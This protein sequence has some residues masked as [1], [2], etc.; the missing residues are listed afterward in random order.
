[1]VSRRQ[2]F[3]TSSELGVVITSRMQKERCGQIPYHFLKNKLLALDCPLHFLKSRKET[4]ERFTFNLHLKLGLTACQSL[5]IE[6]HG[7]MSRLMSQVI[8]LAS[9]SQSVS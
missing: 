9:T 2:Y 5:K 3:E 7:S 4:W 6:G 1:M 8:P